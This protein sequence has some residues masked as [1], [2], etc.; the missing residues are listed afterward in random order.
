MAKKPSAPEVTPADPKAMPAKLIYGYG[1]GEE[2]A[3]KATVQPESKEPPSFAKSIVNLLNSQGNIERLAFETD[4]SFNNEF[5]SVYKAKMRLVPDS[6]LKRISIQDDLVATIVRTRQ[7]HIMPFGR[8]RPDRYSLGYVIEADTK[9]LN[10]MSLEKRQDV[11]ERIN[12]ATKRLWQCGSTE[13]WGDL[14]KTTFSQFLNL[15]VRSAVTVGRA[16]LERIFVKNEFGNDEFHSFRAI[17]AGTI[18][19]ASN[20]K[21]AGDAVRKEA[22]H[23]LQNLKDHKL[24]QEKF[25]N[26]EYAWI[27]VIE[28]KPYQAF[29]SQECAVFNFYPVPDVELGGYPV[30]PID[31]AISAVTTHINITT[32]NKLYFQN[33][34]AAKGM[35]VIKSEDQNTTV[36]NGIKQFFNASINSVNSAWRM[37]VFGCGQQDEISWQPIDNSSRD[38]E[39]QYLT[40]M[41][42][43]IIL[44]AFM[45]SP[46]EL[47]GWSYLSKGTNS[48]S[49]AECVAANTRIYT[50]N[51]LV[52]ISE[53]LGD[54]DQKITNIWSGKKWVEGRAFKSGEKCLCKTE[55]SCGI[56]IETSP[57]HRFLTLDED[58]ET[59][60]KRQESLQVGDFVL[61]NKKPIKGNEDLV[62]YYKGKKLTLEMAEVLGWITGD[63]CLVA[64]RERSGAVIHMFYHPEK[65][66]SEWNRHDTILEAFDL[67]HSHKEF[68]FTDEQKTKMMAQRGVGSIADRK[69]VNLIHDT[70]FYRWLISIG[71]KSS[72]EGKRVPP[73]FYVLP[74]EYRQAFL[75]GYFSADGGKLGEDGDVALTVQPEALREDTRQ[76]LLSLGIRTLPAKGLMRRGFGDKKSFSYKLF[77]K[78]RKE[79]WSQIGF[80]QKHKQLQEVKENWKIEPSPNGVFK[81]YLTL[82]KESYKFHDL[83]KGCRDAI[84]SVIAGAKKCSWTKL[85]DTMDYCG[86]QKPEWME[87]YYVETVKSIQRSEELVPMY[88]VE[89]FDDVH[90]FVADGVVTHNS[91][92]EWR[93][94]A[95]RDVGIRPLL[96]SFEEYINKEIFPWIDPDLSKFCRVRLM[97]LDSDN[98][99][100]EAVRL[101][102]DMAIHMTM[103]DIL[104]R[105]EKKT[106]VKELG[107]DL[108]LNEAFLANI[109]KY[110][111]VGQIQESFLGKEGASKDP[112]MA[113]YR[114]PYWFQM[115]QLI[116]SSKQSANQQQAEQQAAEAGEQANDVKQP[117]KQLGSDAG[118]QDAPSQAN[119]SPDAGQAPP[120][121]LSRSIDQAL[122]VLSKSEEDLPP[123]KRHILDKHR[124][125]VA[126]FMDGFTKDLDD[127]T[128]EIEKV[129]KNFTPKKK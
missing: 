31:T 29:T 78:D 95:S 19:R 27:Q 62:P 51:G 117:P 122:E 44:S 70:D 84:V 34:R 13:G 35:L 71:F 41:N 17:D 113:Y 126:S 14:N 33:G 116:M 91:N 123:A 109:D 68:I 18:Y 43:R 87:N 39:F 26:D 48:Q 115:Q 75:R 118:Q 58:G 52:S 63:G 47:P 5:L 4:P 120:T 105:V 61:V 25:Q 128:M 12:K 30:T 8:P 69:I 104:E 107:G 108:P 112:N 45:M 88:D 9:T 60:W 56:N 92:G 16:S 89:M 22:F 67:N 101:Q 64:P 66:E 82:C 21:E 57:D 1:V 77:I 86:V 38:M 76:L 53:L 7:N 2:E 11:A 10:Q 125:T 40:D 24:N 111:T 97:G 85:S 55:L 102:Q 73:L 93:L 98:A 81:K 36:I 94:E 37:P 114:D 46:D 124:K 23:I 50:A 49:L 79:F 72:T 65:E 106:L 127:A 6:I 3:F 100:K 90:A 96:T 32:H 129:V 59:S 121:D 99:E 83:T 74:V 42:A 15:S 20:Q 119:G 54:A 103:N 110:L 80:I 28:G